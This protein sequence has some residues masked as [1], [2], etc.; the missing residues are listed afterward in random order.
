[1]A[2]IRKHRD[3]WQV[4]IRRKGCT[5]LT[6]TFRRK[7][8]ALE[9]GNQAEVDADRRGL[10]A[11]PRQLERLTVAD[12][13]KRY[14]DE[15]VPRKRAGAIETIILK[16]FLRARVAS[17]RLSEV[18]AS[19]FAAYRDERLKSV[20]PATINR[21]LGII[22]RAFTVAR[23]EWNFPLPN[24]PVT[25][26]QKPKADEPRDRLTRQTISFAA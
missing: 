4:Q 9:W 21:E 14:R 8:D 19:H 25:D 7:A 20:R 18:T 1:M 16:A 11:N 22:Q 26:I 2:T 15:V 3:K 12:L 17:L 5:P 24:N 10:T 13:V 6:R 23:K